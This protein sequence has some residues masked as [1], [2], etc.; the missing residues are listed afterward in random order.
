MIKSELFGYMPCGCKVTAYTLS[1]DSITS[2]TIL[3]FG[4][5]IKNLYVKD[6]NGK[7]DDV[8]C[9]YDDLES[10]LTANGY[11][12]ALIGRV[13]NRI[14]GGKFTLDG[15]EYHLTK[16]EGNKN[17][18]HGG[19]YGFNYKVWSAEPVDG[20]EPKLIL[21]Y[22]SPDGEECFPGTLSV[23]VT[24]TLTKT[25][26][27][28]LHYEATTDKKTIINMTSHGYFNLSGC[29]NGTIDDHYI[30]VDGDRINNLD[31]ELIP[32]GTFL[33][34]AGTPYDL[35]SEKRIGD[36]FK[37]DHPMLR[38]F[39]GIDN[40]FCCTDYDGKL[41]LRARVRDSKSGR[42]MNV[43]TDAPCVQVYT[44]NMIVESDPCFKGGI[45]QYKHCAV[46]LETQ[47]MPDSINHE[48]FTNIILEPDGKY[49]TTTIYEFCN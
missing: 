35:R 39:G 5:V 46:C 37:E 27:L 17:T 29:G 34:V 28:A 3:D 23:K 25:G 14:G 42:L 20:E 22:V 48:G 15:V 7:A 12:G 13:G 36:I 43:I 18:L 33:N 41:K 10:Y 44:S 31:N 11:Q 49:D 47:A 1:N 16:N 4:G 30:C 6:R 26:G 9:G 40:N 19:K 21:T 8:V 24:Y 45:P 32:D 38:E 2:A